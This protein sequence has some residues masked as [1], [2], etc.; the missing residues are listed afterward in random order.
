MLKTPGIGRAAVVHVRTGKAFRAAVDEIRDGGHWEDPSEA[1][2]RSA[3][4]RAQ[5][6]VR[7]AAERAQAAVRE[8]AD[9]GGPLAARLVRPGLETIGLL[10]DRIERGYASP[11]ATQA[12]LAY[13][14]R[15]DAVP[16]AAEFVH[17]RLA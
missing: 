17:E 3:A 2:I 16:P 9:D 12:E 13:V 8:A 7:E 1:S 14:D 5:A 4:E 6:A 15:A 11:R 10:G